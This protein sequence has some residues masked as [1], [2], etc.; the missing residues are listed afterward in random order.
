MMSVGGLRSGD[1][2]TSSEWRL[3]SIYS[4]NNNN[5]DVWQ[6][7]EVVDDVSHLETTSTN[8]GIKGSTLDLR[9]STRTFDSRGFVGIKGSLF[10]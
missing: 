10:Y 5:N 2:E 3:A 4:H 6:S 9:A 8:N 1:M 7:T